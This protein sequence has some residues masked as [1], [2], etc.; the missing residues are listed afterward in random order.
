MCDYGHGHWPYCFNSF[1]KHNE[2]WQDDDAWDSPVPVVI[3]AQKVN[4]QVRRGTTDIK[5]VG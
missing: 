4:L 3:G 2:K 1:R 5:H